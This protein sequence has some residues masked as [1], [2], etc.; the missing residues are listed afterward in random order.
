M[1]AIMDTKE[2]KFAWVEWL[3]NEREKQDLSQA[4]LARRA[5]LTRAAISDYENRK[6]PNPEIHALVNISTA[7]G[8]PPEYLPRVA[9]LLPPEMEI[10]AE[11]E[12]I[13]HEVGQLNKQDQQ[14]V[15]AYIRMKK[16][17]RKKK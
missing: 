15:L 3:K 7:L 16:N 4:E 10:D 2:D 1:Y 12:Q 5:K 14:E 8:Y 17:L 13:L 9:G 6:R 11:I